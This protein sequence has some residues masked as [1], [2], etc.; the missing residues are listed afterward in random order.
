MR[1]IKFRAR[2]KSNGEWVYG[3]YVRADGVKWGRIYFPS[4]IWVEVDPETV[5]E[6]TGRKDKDNAEIYEGDIA[7]IGKCNYELT[8]FGG[9]LPLAKDLRVIGNIHQNKEL[10][11]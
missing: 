2:T 4:G 3:Y 9:W 10:L 8:M 6:Y 5:G 1:E 11:K 7:K